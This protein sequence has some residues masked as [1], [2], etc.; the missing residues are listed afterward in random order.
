MNRSLRILAGTLALALP[1]AAAAGCG[2]EKKKTVKQE[3]QAAQDYLSNAKAASFTL[4]FDDAQGNFAKFITKDGDTPPAVVQ[5]MLKGSI[6]YI[7]DP[8]GDATL[9]SVQSQALNPSDL[10]AAMEKV[11]IAFVVRDDKA[12]LFE[13][14]L[15][16]GD[17]Y[18]HVNLKEI[19][20][21]AKAG[22]SEDFDATLDQG[23][24]EMDPRFAQG[25]A[26]VRAGKWLKLPLAKY[27]D[28]LKDLAGTFTGI[29]PPTAAPGQ[30]YDYSALGSKAYAA[31]KPFVKVTDAN[32]DSTDRVLDVK[33]QVR[34]A[35]KALL[36]LLK[37]EK[38]LPFG[39]LIADV[40]PAE[41]DKQVKDGEARG[42]ITLH[43]SHLT[44]VS[45]DLESVRLLAN[46]PGTDS[47]AGVKIT[48]DVDDSAEQLVAP[49]NLSTL[50]LGSV[51]DDFL[52]SFSEMT[53]SGTAG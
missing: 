49:T 37:A 52:T 16:A 3:F 7:A 15:V 46:D 33:V 41:I 22:G 34:P 40:T 26:D 35:L 11:N 24:S 4:R 39:A 8:A 20:V 36:S 12:D 23:L 51:L 17:L 48:L 6:T 45:V 50:D 38:G 43:E 28:Q 42:T 14:R 21:L 1:L 9:K 27:L 25:L 18:A 53:S 13:L 30:E 31:I 19:G 32:D 44:K 47:F 5:A 29:T 10:K 2:V